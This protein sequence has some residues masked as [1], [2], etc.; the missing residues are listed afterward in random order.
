[1]MQKKRVKKNILVGIIVLLVMPFVFADHGTEAASWS[2][3]SWFYWSPFIVIIAAAMLAHYY[4][5]HGKNK[6]EL[7][8][9]KKILFILI[10]LVTVFVTA[11]I[12]YETVHSNINSW[13]HGPVHW[14]ADFEVWKCDK[15]LDMIDPKGFAN[16]VGTPVFHEHNDDRIHVEGDVM[17]P[18]DISMTSFFSVIGGKIDATSLTYPT[19]YGSVEMREGMLCN[20][21]PAQLQVFVYKIS[22]PHNTKKWIMSQEKVAD[23]EEYLLSPYTNVPPGDCIIIELEE[24]KEKTER[25]C[26]SYEIAM[27][28][29]E[30]QWQ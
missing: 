16:K 17:H 30:I 1:M 19:I 21:K 5:A 13:T 14:H 15:K 20:G 26:E 9:I 10:I 12:F 8:S 11:V 3:S 18:E 4:E 24:E 23:I 7:E 22:N 6:K 2:K 25:I 27:K 28:K 29:G